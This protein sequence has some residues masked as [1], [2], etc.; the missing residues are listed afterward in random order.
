M[1]VKVCK[2]CECYCPRKDL[3]HKMTLKMIILTDRHLM[4]R[5]KNYDWM[6][7]S[8]LKAIDPSLLY[9]EHRVCKTC[10]RLFKEVEKLMDL[11]LKIAQL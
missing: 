6:Q 1:N 8:D 2:Y 4:L 3:T 11:E 10:Y 9:L 5:G 7:R